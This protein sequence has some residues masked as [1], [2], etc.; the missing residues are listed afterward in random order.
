MEFI[1]NN[2]YL[3]LDMEEDQLPFVVCRMLGINYN[4]IE[5]PSLGFNTPKFRI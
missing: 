3:P 1:L 5:S 4:D 2:V